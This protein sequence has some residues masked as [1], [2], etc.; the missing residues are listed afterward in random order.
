MNEV[1]NHL[2]TILNNTPAMVVH[3]DTKFNFLFVN[4]AYADSYPLIF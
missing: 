4:K 1:N 2:I 3:L